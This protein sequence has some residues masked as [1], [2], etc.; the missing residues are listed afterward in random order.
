MIA[1]KSPMLLKLPV[2]VNDNNSLF[3]TLIPLTR[4]SIKNSSPMTLSSCSENS[5]LFSE[6]RKIRE[7]DQS[8]NRHSLNRLPAE[9]E[10]ENY[11]R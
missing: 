3:S 9:A 7:S 8:E 4:S 11:V 5:T 6:Y 10:L 1:V 2:N